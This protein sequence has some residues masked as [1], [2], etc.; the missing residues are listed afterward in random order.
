M[1][2]RSLNMV[3]LSFMNAILY[4]LFIPFSIKLYSIGLLASLQC[5]NRRYCTEILEHIN[6]IILIF[7]VIKDHKDI[8]QV[9]NTNRRTEGVREQVSYWYAFWKKCLIILSWA[10]RT[11]PW[12][13]ER[14]GRYCWRSRGSAPPPPPA[15]CRTSLARCTSNLI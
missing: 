4:I 3:D 14:T 12:P 15:R 9:W 2:Y 5:N 10:V 11:S 7:K 13:R 8:L 6:N 1:L